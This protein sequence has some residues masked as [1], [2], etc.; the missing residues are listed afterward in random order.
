MDLT[1]TPEEKR[2]RAQVREWLHANVPRE[3]RPLDTH[4]ACAYDVAW[5]RKQY[6]GGWAGVSWPVEYG[7]RGLSLIEQLIWHE[8]YARADAPTVGNLFVG[9]NHGG[10]TLMVRGTEAQKSFHLPRILTGEAIWC[11]G[12][13]EPG[14]GSD[15]AGIQT[16]GVIDG[17]HLVVNGSK[18]WTSYAHHAHFQELLVRTDSTGES[19]HSGLTWVI[20]DMKLPGVSVRPI[21]NMAGDL[22]FCQVFYDDVRIPLSNVVGEVG[23]GWSVAMSTL[24]FE[25]GTSVIAYQ[26][27]M[28][29][30][31][32]HLIELA[33]RAELPDGTGPA[34]ED[35]E[36]AARLAQL[37]AEISG[38]RAMTYAEI[39]RGLSRPVPGPEGAMVS[40]YHGELQKRL[41]SVAI[42]ILGDDALAW[43]H[44]GLAWTYLTAFR[45]TIAGGTAEIRR[46]IIG[47]RV[48]HLPKGR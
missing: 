4:A 6:D 25:R 9:L 3:P 31:I 48:L 39:S 23:E 21:R 29:R 35:A 5:Q 12:F 22:D 14:A 8:E 45:H 15:L 2:F 11:Q 24:G 17:H 43:V 30:A 47:E 34:I 37:R 26:I 16:R 28:S 19:R 1:F 18:I 10:P 27:E 20:C 40:L 32:E 7:G 42:D 46:N 41:R 44:G 36:I 13:S 33:R 38:M